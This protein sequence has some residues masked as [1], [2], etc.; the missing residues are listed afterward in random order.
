M[1]CRPKNI[2]ELSFF[3]NAPD[4]AST[5]NRVL[6]KD[7]REVMVYRVVTSPDNGSSQGQVVV[8]K[9]AHTRK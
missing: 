5:V 8:T 4:G 3:I 7:P 6:A 2:P 9:Q 1:A